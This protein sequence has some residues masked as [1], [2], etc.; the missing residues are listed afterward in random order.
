MCGSAK[1]EREGG[2]RHRA[3][4]KKLTRNVGKFTSTTAVGANRRNDVTRPYKYA[5]GSAEEILN[6]TRVRQVYLG[7]S[8]RL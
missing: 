6:N 7:E 8:F 5:E 2:A 3:V 4:Q 1:R